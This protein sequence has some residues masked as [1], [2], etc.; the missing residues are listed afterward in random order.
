VA[1]VGGY[2]L[3]GQLGR[4]VASGFR[5]RIYDPRRLHSWIG[6]ACRARF[7]HV[8]SGSRL[9]QLLGRVEAGYE[10]I[11]GRC[12]LFMRRAEYQRNVVHVLDEILPPGG[13]GEL[14][15]SPVL[16]TE[17][18]PWL[19]IMANSG[20]GDGMGAGGRRRGRHCLSLGGEMIS[21]LEETEMRM[22]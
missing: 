8:G 5:D 17:Y 1:S 16:L 21:M 11:N 6:R 3:S 4:K 19:R 14:L 15:P 2:A 7:E 13:L 18:L 9:R 20:D 22:D 12:G 10:E